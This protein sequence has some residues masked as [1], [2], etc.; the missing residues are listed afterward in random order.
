M[1]QLLSISSSRSPL[2]SS[3]R[4]P[5]RGLRRGAALVL[6]CLGLVAAFPVMDAQASDENEQAAS[7]RPIAEVAS[8]QG[9]AE[10]LDAN[11]QARVLAIGDRIQAGESV[12]T[13]PG[14]TVG[15]WHDE[16]L[17]SS[18]RRAGPASIET[19]TARRASPSK[20]APS[21]SSTR[22]RPASRSSS[23]LS[24][25]RAPSSAAT[26]RHASCARRRAPT[27]CSAIGSS[28]SPSSAAPK[29]RARGRA[30]ASSPIPAK[31]CSRRRATRIAFPSSAVRRRSPMRAP[32]S[33]RPA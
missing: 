5:M 7:A 32:R 10:A 26:A 24:I 14:S 20:T 19:P 30:T 12:R 33:I 28:P 27:R 13:A 8:V 4:A 23:S 9:T 1:Q 29:A 25:R 22:A 17:A 18:P 11:G 3:W 15:L 2:G 16:A 21:A 6:G 31:P